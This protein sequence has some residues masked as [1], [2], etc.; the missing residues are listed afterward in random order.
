[1]LREARVWPNKGTISTILYN[2]KEENIV[3]QKNNVYIIKKT[4]FKTKQQ[5]QTNTNINKTFDCSHSDYWL[6]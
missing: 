3:Y 6:Q 1:M 5:I 2:N 4:L